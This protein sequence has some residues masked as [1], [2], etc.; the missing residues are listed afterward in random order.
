MTITELKNEYVWTWLSLLLTSLLSGCGAQAIRNDAQAQIN[1]GHFEQGLQTYEQ[2]LKQYPDNVALLAGKTSAQ[3]LIFSQLILSANTERSKGNSLHA[4]E[5]LQR[6]LTIDPDNS[7]A[8]LLMLDI[9]REIRQKNQLDMANEL[10]AKG[11][12]EQATLVIESALKDNPAH[13]EFLALQR[14]IELENHQVELFSSHLIETRPV[15]LDFRDANLRAVLEL[16]T[17]NS[18]VNFVIDKD[19]RADLHATV[20]L[21][22]TGLEDALQLI[23]AT[24]Q[25]AYKVLDATTVFIYPRTTEKIREYQD[26][27]IRAFYLSNADVKQTAMLLKSMLKIQDPYVDEKLNMIMVRE[28]PE[29]VRLAERIIGLK[30]LAE[31]EVL[32]ELEVLEIQ[33]SNNT[34]LGIQYPDTLTL[35]PILPEGAAKFTLGN[36]KDINKNNIGIN[37]PSVTAHFHNNVGDVNI[38][39]NP[40][41]RA[42]NREKAK[43]V[44]GDKLPIV[45]TTGNVANSG[46]IS[47]SVQYVDVGLKLD[48]EP[49]IYL[50]D[51]VAINVGLEV[52]SL[53]QEIKTAAG[54]VV[55]QIGTRTANTILRLHDGQTQ[56]LAGLISNQERMSANRI[57]ALGAMPLLGRLFS[58][59]S[60]NDQRSEI[61]LS[62]TPHIVRNIRRPDLN[63]AEFWSGT[64]TNFHSRPLTL[65]PRKKA[66]A[67]PN[68]GAKPIAEDNTTL[69]D[70]GAVE[71]STAAFLTLSAP[72][73]V[74]A[75]ETFSVDIQLNTATPLRGMPVQL[76]FDRQKLEIVDAEEGDFLCQGGALTSLSK[77]LEQREGRASLVVMR[78]KSEELKGTG[79]FARFKFKAVSAGNAEIKLSSARAIANQ[80]VA[81]ALPAALQVTVH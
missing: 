72:T 13:P 58:A 52:S 44:I 31:P 29:T 28:A 62:I 8:K 39:A 33:H 64:E 21:R 4:R 24:N 32:M 78:Q 46:F 10:L 7:R 18:G 73:E 48:V 69:P 74:Q 79:I 50:D 76:Q 17:R 56:L 57:P 66:S 25:L 9:D 42:R 15:S 38:L 55:Y 30:D 3:N 12:T 34:T 51:D 71:K 23:T 19:V 40:K 49:N 26:L 80:P 53:E 63:L 14:N 36:I 6:V 5:I 35:T 61:V 68:A 22:Q 43:I 41:V 16:L 77:A 60:D 59:Q 65:A 54:S 20:F 81:V 75:G 1:A 37:A 47:E 70:P 27:V 11:L 67:E 2:G 45:T